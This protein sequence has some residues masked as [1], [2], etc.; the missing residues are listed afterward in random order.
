MQTLGPSQS[1]LEF[2]KIPDTNLNLQIPG[3]LHIYIAANIYTAQLTRI[4]M[5]VVD[6]QEEWI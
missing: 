1:S 5:D 2:L 6:R 3:L 4:L